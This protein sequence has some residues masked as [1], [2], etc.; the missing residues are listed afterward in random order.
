MDIFKYISIII[1]IRNDDFTPL[2]TPRTVYENDRINLHKRVLK[3]LHNMSMQCALIF[4]NEI[5]LKRSL[6]DINNN[7]IK[8]FVQTNSDWDILIISELKTP[9]Q[10]TD[11][12]GYNLI[13]QITQQ[14]DF[15]NFYPN[16][17]IV[18]SNFMTKVV[19]NQP[20]D[21]IN[22]Y[23]YTTPFLENLHTNCKKKKYTVGAVT[24]ISILQTVE[25][26]Y[27]WRE[28]VI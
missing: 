9:I 26:K 27:I 8:T 19:N 28:L 17:Y 13:K 16:I 6:A 7:E 18:S 4:E 2:L 5:Y 22:I 1:G 25:V 14:N 24:N 10:L 15:A 23:V 12:D 20:T 21:N 11:V 3:K